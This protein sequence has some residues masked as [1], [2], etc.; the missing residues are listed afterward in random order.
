MKIASSVAMIGAL[1]FGAQ[2]HAGGDA[3]AGKTAFANQCA[4][5]H[6]VEAGKNGFGPSLAGVV[7]RH[8]GTIRKPFHEGRDGRDVTKAE[9][10][11]TDDSVAQ[12]D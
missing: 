3:A 2:A 9:P 8:S 6:T 5:C 4:S 12:I 10:A 11:A 1:L 7:G